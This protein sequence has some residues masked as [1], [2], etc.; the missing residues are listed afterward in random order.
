MAQ[1]HKGARVYMAARLPEA[2]L[3]ERLAQEIAALDATFARQAS[4]SDSVQ[5]A[6]DERRRELNEALSAA[7]APGTVAR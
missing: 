4:P 6:Y 3:H 7:L 2:P 5:A 1:H